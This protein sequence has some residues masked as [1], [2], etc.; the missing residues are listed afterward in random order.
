MDGF[1]DKALQK[2]LDKKGPFPLT[3]QG[4]LEPDA[5]VKFRD[6]VS[7]HGYRTFKPAKERNRSNRVQAYKDKNWQEYSKNI[8]QASREYQIYMNAAIKLGYEYL[9]MDQA[10]YEESEKETRETPGYAE[11]LKIDTESV[12]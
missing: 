10:Q 9:G 11:R 3:L 7:E 2:D 1:D 6:I 4:T 5:F 12:R 8:S